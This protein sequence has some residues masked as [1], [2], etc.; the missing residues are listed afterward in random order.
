MNQ[1][2]RRK[3]LINYLLNE[4]EDY[5][6]IKIPR[7]ED[8]QKILLRSLMNIRPAKNIAKEFLKIQ[9]E[10]LNEELKKQEIINITNLK[11]LKKNI[12]LIKEDITK[13]E[14]DA[15][16]NAA[17]SSLLGCFIPCHKCID[18]AIH[19][20][21]GIQLRLECSK[22]MNIQQSEEPTGKAKITKAYNLPCKYIIHTV[23]P[24]IDN[25][26]KNSD[27]ETLKSCYTSCLKLADKYKLKSI[28]F[29]CIST[30]EFH[31]QNDIAAKIAV[32]TVIKY[33]DETKSTIEVI[34]DVFKSEDYEIYKKLL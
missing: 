27:I 16:V 31:F 3:Y 14:V 7:Y 9:D 6:N 10:Y 24:Y 30:G 13:L 1:N 29:C 2:D 8:E 5:K 12:Y 20:K 11:P 17:N 23:G 15:I 34:F 25:I 26:L 32:D 18:N 33:L 22:I 19:S 4:K 28:A 21:A